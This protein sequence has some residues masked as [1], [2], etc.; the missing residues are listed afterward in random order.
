MESTMI[1]EH[2][3]Q[4]PMIDIVKFVCALLVVT[5][6]IYPLSSYPGIFAQYINF[7]LQK[8]IA[9][10][11]VPFYFTSAGFFLFQKIDIE[12][13]DKSITKKYIIKLLCLLGIW[14]LLLFVGKTHH[15]WYMNALIVS[16]CIVNGLSPKK[17]SFRK[18]IVV[19]ILFYCIG[20]IGDSYYGLIRPL[21]D[22]SVIGYPIKVYN[23]IFGTTRNGFFMGFPFLLL[24]GIIAKKKIRIKP[25]YA[26]LGLL[27]SMGMLVFE[28][29]MLNKL[30]LAKD[31]NMYVSLIPTVY[32]L[33]LF[34]VN[35]KMKPK[36]IYVRIRHVGVVTYFSH[37]FIY[38]WL[39]G[40]RLI[41]RITGFKITNS[42][43]IYFITIIFTLILEFCIERL[44]EKRNLL[45]LRYLY[46]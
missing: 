7:G 29:L 43:S 19:A 8:C 5:L 30:K 24:G 22:S 21:L 44:S 41:E 33:M 34:S 20:L 23:K 46:S 36:K 32:F 42:L 13:F 9:R 39:F 35:L 45:F 26:F 15:L 14:R 40:F 38:Q 11:A 1:Q 2:K 25:F 3:K 18:L 31:T 27:I 10:I 28:A 12:K 37:F 16:V 4:Y 6:H 17:I